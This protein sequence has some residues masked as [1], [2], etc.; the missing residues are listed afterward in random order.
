MGSDKTNKQAHTFGSVHFDRAKIGGSVWK[1]YAETKKNKIK[2]IPT[3]HLDSVEWND[4]T[5]L[6]MMVVVV[7]FLI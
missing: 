5:S 2:H 7:V 4:K 1:F 6:S 3:F